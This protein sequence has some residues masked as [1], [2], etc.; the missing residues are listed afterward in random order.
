M[1]QVFADTAFFLALLNPD[2][3]LHRDAKR[4]ND[5]SLIPRVDSERHVCRT[6]LT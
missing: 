5:A 4:L 2:D 3:E 6:A 1:K